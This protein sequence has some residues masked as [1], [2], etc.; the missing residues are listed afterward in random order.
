MK[1]RPNF[2]EGGFYSSNSD[3]LKALIEHRLQ[4]ERNKI[5]TAL[6]QKKIIGGVIPHAGHVYC[7]SQAV[8]FFEIVRQSRQKFDVVILVNP[9]HHGEGLPV[10]IDDHDFWNTSLGNIKVD[11]ELAE[12]T[13]LPFDV[14]SQGKEHSAEVIVPYIQYF[15]GLEIPFLPV[16]FGAQSCHN[17]E[18]LAQILFEACQKLN[19]KP[20]FIASSDFNHFA[21][22]QIG[23]EHDD[24]ALDALMHHDLPEFERRIQQKNISICGYGAIISL[25]EFARLES[26]DFKSVIL[27]QGHSGEVAP[28][29]RVVDYVSILVYEE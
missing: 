11:R 8:H 5:N 15:F 28:S 21:S 25:F 20:L 29:D 22:A 17:A 16:S 19:R 3:E 24:Y 7:A 10:S 26:A 9:N 27:R 6:A 18:V 13:G 2:A 4:Q 23:K 14:V 1:I 12:V